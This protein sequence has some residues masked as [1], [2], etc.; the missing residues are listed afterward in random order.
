MKLFTL[1]MVMI[2]LNPSSSSLE[3]MTT[4]FITPS[5]STP[6]PA[7]P[8]LT[9]SH[10]AQ[11]SSSH[12]SSNT[13]LIF[14]VGNHTFNTKFSISN[15]SKF[16]MF[17]NSTSGG[18][19]IISCQRQV[20]F[21]FENM[22]ELWMKGLKFIGCGSNTFS[23]ITTFTI[24]NCIF[25]GMN[26]SGT[27]LDITETNLTI[28]NSSFVSNRVGR[29]LKIFDLN[30]TLSMFLR[31]G[32]A[33]FMNKSS[34]SVIKCTF[35]NNSAEVGGAIYS[36]SCA[37]NNISISNSTFISNRAAI[38]SVHIQDCNQTDNSKA[39]SI[40]GV[41]AIFNTTLIIN[42]S[43]FTNNTSEA[44]DGGALAIEQK[45]VTI[46]DSSEFNGN[47]ASSYG[48][49]LVI[50]ESD[51]TISSSKFH[52]NSATQGGVM[53]LYELSVI[54]STENVYN[55]NSA[56][57]S[58]GV[59]SIDEDSLL[60]DKYSLFI[61]NRATTGGV[62]YLVRS[63]LILQD[64]VFSF[65]QATGSGGVMY[66]LE[67]HQEV[68]FQG[69]SNLTH[70]FAG[71]G[72]AIYGVESM[73]L[74]Y[75]GNIIYTAQFS[76]L[77]VAFNEANDSGGGIY[78]YRSKFT[79]RLIGSIANISSNKARKNGGGI[80]AINS[81]I[82]C[83]ESYRRANNWPYQNLMVFANNSAQRGGGL[84]LESAVQLRIQKVSHVILLA[85][86]KAKLNASI[87]FTSNFAQYGAAVYV[88]DQTNFDVCSRG[89]SM[90]KSTATSNDECFVQVFSSSLALAEESQTSAANIE[91]TTNNYENYTES[92]LIFGGL[93]DRCLPDPIRAE[94]SVNG[95]VRKE[96]DGFT[97]L[98]LISN[99]ADTEQISS[100]PVR[101]CFC[102]PDGNSNCSY[103]PPIIHVKKGES[104]NVSLV[105][106]DQ[107]NHT[108]ANVTIHSSL[109]H[110]ESS[111][112]ED[113]STQVTEDDCTNLNF[114]IHSPYTSEE[115]ILYAEGP[116]R[117]AERSQS[118]VLVTFQPCTCPIGFQPNYETNDCVCVC[119]SRLSPYFT[120]H[121][122]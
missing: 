28:V 89:Y 37:Y 117:N 12:L 91:F 4:L 88:A 116:C 95:H 27:A 98:K 33:I 61:Y 42:S 100:L 115:L 46:T 70:N 82:T 7:K 62:F 112:G 52:E 76:C 101:V 11:N 65:N 22:T 118:R 67:S 92:T 79:S 106:V 44:G 87:H 96:I 31:V 16:F 21:N 45:S 72:G 36:N 49:T 85:A 57:L 119:D 69:L 94:I 73:F 30:A 25:Q 78:L 122:C 53:H 114:S 13:M 107:V 74:L 39:R 121:S 71:T 10:F 43:T 103:K 68:V 3:G 23:L 55:S 109:N 17:T 1:V 15:V 83:I 66:I 80:H 81:L 105:A 20:S 84:Y 58:G 24:E 41:I 35:V 47:S 56:N 9:L 2:H 26:D 90:I 86:Q 54:A 60:H 93:L 14:L 50:R 48:G 97:Y 75:S 99:I 64:G 38:N 63:E 8:C 32:G 59:V 110:T 102:T 108:I 120:D 111:L 34:L 19:H 6:C 51:V 5:S 18:D 29:C 113:Q 77:L 40:G 104:F